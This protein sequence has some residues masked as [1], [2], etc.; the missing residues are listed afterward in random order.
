[1]KLITRKK[2]LDDPHF[3]S[4]LYG[5]QNSNKP[6]EDEPSFEAG[7]YYDET[8]NETRFFT[9]DDLIA[10]HKK[11]IADF[12]R[13]LD[14]KP[15]I[16]A[17]VVATLVVDTPQETRGIAYF[18]NLLMDWVEAQ[19][20][21]LVFVPFY[22]TN[23]FQDN[24]IKNHHPPTKKAYTQLQ[25]F[26]RKDDY[27]GGIILSSKEDVEKFLPIYFNLVESNYIPYGFF[28]SKE[29]KTV[30]SYHY[31]EQL[32]CYCLSKKFLQIIEHFIE[33]KNL[34]VNE[35]FTFYAY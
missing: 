9:E 3:A 35:R 27:E 28:Y 26:I 31:S 17:T 24:E 34:T 22:K 16:E 14:S 12:E 21:T 20:L 10:A 23:W 15:K 18:T 2:A 32:W 7:N 29:L 33:L 6:F 13:L 1:M 30:F 5:W 19:N 8:Q 25:D 4:F 11:K